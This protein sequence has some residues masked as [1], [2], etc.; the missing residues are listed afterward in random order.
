MFTFQ[1]TEIRGK[2]TYRRISVVFLLLFILC[3]YIFKKDPFYLTYLNY[4]GIMNNNLM[5]VSTPCIGNKKGGAHFIKWNIKIYENFQLALICYLPVMTTSNTNLLSKILL[6]QKLFN[7]Y[8]ISLHSQF[9]KYPILLLQHKCSTTIHCQLSLIKLLY[10][11]HLL[12][13]LGTLW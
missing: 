11:L 13:I 2:R 1:I 4:V 12:S 10:F 6:L 5:T 3:V 7:I 9:N 8:Q